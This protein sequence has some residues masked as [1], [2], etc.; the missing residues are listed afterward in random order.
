MT[1]LNTS[2]R[3]L[4]MT[5]LAAGFAPS[6]AFA[7]TADSSAS[8]TAV[9]MSVGANYTT[10]DYGDVEDTAVLSVPVS[11]RV[12]TGNF[13]VRVTVP[14]VRLDG[15]GSLIDSGLDD[16]GSSGGSGRGRG[17][18]GSG[19]NSGSGSGVDIG[20][21]DNDPLNNGVTSGLGD[22]TVAASYELQLT[23]NVWLDTTGRVKLPTASQSRRLGTGQI[24]VT[25]GADLVTEV[26]GVTLYAGG[27]RR[28]VGNS[29]TTNYRDVW[30]A[31]LGMSA[32]ASDNITLGADL[33]WQQSVTAGNGASRDITVWSSFRVA[34]PVRLR[35]FAGTGLSTNSHDFTGGASLTYRF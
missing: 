12:R 26:G 22:V 19:S 24:D 5:I 20:D 1:A 25:A 31:G 28:F 32:R 17:R 34:G 35:V 7:Q 30:G 33:D 14:W 3:L 16:G 29:A 4:A 2:G 11:L 8:E 18:G 6:S 9:S 10:G 27:R 21:D 15:P 13:N 23:R